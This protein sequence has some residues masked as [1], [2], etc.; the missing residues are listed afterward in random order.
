MIVD[1]GFLVDPKPAVTL[2]Y[3]EVLRL[4]KEAMV[5]TCS[6]FP[7]E[8]YYVRIGSLQITLQRAVRCIIQFRKSLLVEQKAGG[9]GESRNVG[10]PTHP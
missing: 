1:I 10:S 8:R 5:K 3:T 9:G 7:Q 4:P 6:R 2:S